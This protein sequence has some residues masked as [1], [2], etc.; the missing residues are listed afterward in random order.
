MI[1]RLSHVVLHLAPLSIVR[2]THEHMP[3]Q[4]S[5]Q[6]RPETSIQYVS[7]PP[8][9]NPEGYRSLLAARFARAYCC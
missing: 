1:L 3:G 8:G 2:D 9:F 5:L 7:K 4:Q 6:T